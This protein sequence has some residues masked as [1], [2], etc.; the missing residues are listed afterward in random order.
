MLIFLKKIVRDKCVISSSFVRD[1]CV[2]FG[3]I[4]VY[5][6]INL[7][8]YLYLYILSIYAVLFIKICFIT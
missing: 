4:S 2:V 6:R 8:F 3:P 1:K 7:A 5:S